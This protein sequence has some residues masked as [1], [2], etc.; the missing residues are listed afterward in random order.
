MVKR[1]LESA[2]DGV[3]VKLVPASTMGDRL[4]P[5]LLPAVRGKGVFVGD[6][7]KML[8]RGE[9]DAAVHSM[10][11]LPTSLGEGLEIS[12][13]PA[14]EDRRDVLVS[15]DGSRLEQLHPGAKVGTSS[16]RRR[17]QVLAKRAE[18]SVVEITGNVD[19]RLRKVQNGDYDA[20]ILAAAGLIRLGEGDRIT[21]YFDADD[22][23]PAPCQGAL[24][25]EVARGSGIGKVVAAVDD[26]VLRAETMSERAFAE[27]LGSDCD[28]PAGASANCEAGGLSIAGVIL[29]P[30][31]S[32]SV[33]GRVAGAAERAPEL[34]RAL[35][36]DLLS[37]GGAEILEGVA[38]L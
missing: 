6:L 33:R 32:R 2:V 17:A 7:E 30:D 22:I 26:K 10:K 35:A 24:A 29:T 8:Q 27:T 5:Q 1:M 23:A 28:V 18:L 13:V 14:R 38:A 16:L 12:A 34:G 9:I 31:G 15:S 11:D 4:Q 19:T 21:Q 3:K 37:K 36:R 25:V 20:I